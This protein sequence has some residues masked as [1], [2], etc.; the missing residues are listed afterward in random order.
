MALIRHRRNTSQPCAHSVLCL[1]CSGTSPSPKPDTT[2][3]RSLE[4][5]RRAL[6]TGSWLRLRTTS[7]VLPSFQPAFLARIKV[8]RRCRLAKQHHPFTGCTHDIRMRR[9][10]RR[11]Y[12][13]RGIRQR[14][15]WT[16]AICCW[17]RTAPV[18]GCNRNN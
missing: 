8:L 4:P 16:H 11:N 12:R 3:V 7:V 1:L 9:I 13:S 18:Q 14:G 2:A 6:I 10:G 5:A 17:Y 15:V